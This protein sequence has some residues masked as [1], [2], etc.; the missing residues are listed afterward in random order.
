MVITNVNQVVY[1]GD[2]VTTAFPFTFTITDATEVYLQLVHEDDTVT[3][4]TQDFYV[5]VTN[6]T[7][8]YPGYAPGSEPPE[9]NRPPNVQTGEKLIIYRD[10][11]MTQEINLGD[12]WPFTQIEFGLDK[13]T[14]ICQQ[15]YSYT[16][17]KLDAA[18]ASMFQ[19]A[20]IV[21]DSNKLQHITDQYN[22]I[23][24]NAAAAAESE[25]NAAASATSA[26]ASN[27]SATNTANALINFLE[28]KET[29]TAPAVDTTLTISGA[30]ADAKI[31]GKVKYYEL[32]ELRNGTIGNAGNHNAI[33]TKNIQRIDF[34]C[35][36]IRVEF[37]GST[38]ADKFA[39]G[40]IVF[41]TGVYDGMESDDAVTPSIPRHTHNI[42]QSTVVY[43][44]KRYAFIRT[45]DLV[46][47]THIAFQILAKSEDTQEPLRIATNQYSI[48][49]APV[50]V[51]QTDTTLS[52]AGAAADAKMVGKMV[53]FTD[54]MFDNNSAV[55]EWT[56]SNAT[57]TINNG[58]MRVTSTTANTTAAVYHPINVTGINNLAISMI[59][60]TYD[61]EIIA[62]LYTQVKGTVISNISLTNG[63]VVDVSGYNTVYL[64][65]L[66][67]RG[68]RNFPAGVYTE[69]SEIMIVTGNKVKE[70]MPPY[71]A[72]PHGILAYDMV[73]DFP[74]QIEN[75]ADNSLR[76]SIVSQ[77]FVNNYSVDGTITP[78]KLGSG[79]Y[80]GND[81][82]IKRRALKKSTVKIA[83]I[84]DTHYGGTRTPDFN[85]INNI[86]LFNQAA[87]NIADVAIHLGDIVTNYYSATYMPNL[88]VYKDTVETA[89][90]Q[91]NISVPFLVAKGNHD[92]G[93]NGYT[94]VSP[95]PDTYVADTYFVFDEDTGTYYKVKSSEE[96]AVLKVAGKTFYTRGYDLISNQEYY[97]LMEDTYPVGVVFGELY[98]G[99]YY[100]DVPDT[101][102]RIICLNEYLIDSGT[103]VGINAAQLTFLENSL[104][105]SKTIITISHTSNAMNRI[106]TIMSSFISDGGVYVGHLH[107]HSHRD[108]YSIGGGN[109]NIGVNCGLIK[110]E[111][112]DTYKGF[113]FDVFEVYSKDKYLYENRFGVWNQTEY[114]RAEN[115]IF[116]YESAALLT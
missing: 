82:V 16:N 18:L 57:L 3:T 64:G 34:D 46:D 103:V 51:M 78:Q 67:G 50:G 5:D 11:P 7:V 40:W 28:S 15:I 108:T 94:A 83:L 38:V 48:R 87:N 45:K 24:A 113:S 98:G 75:T 14:M 63:T 30:T 26:S 79:L 58:V 23:D 107:G 85:S 62:R 73:R 25:E 100:Y 8:H 80:K 95:A 56:L 54:N 6:N 53:T 33:C 86:N 42:D 99:Y 102:I 49:Y 93:I 112:V 68:S 74:I 76:N 84:T 81:A 21:T 110:N 31:T 70:Y 60:K 111:D 43:D 10:V 104:N 12:K 71:T 13:L 55:S 41:G 39:I 90:S 27:T 59:A 105:T 72:E 106:G 20:G 1:Q 32:P 96:F 35:E 114:Q 19:L 52:V 9:A 109:S 4:I 77:E 2:G 69:Y 101:D 115:R 22:A 37:V 44:T 97:E 17:R 92:L 29:L 88:T 66:A 61:G 91:F 47:Y 36:Y 89:V 65:L 116:S